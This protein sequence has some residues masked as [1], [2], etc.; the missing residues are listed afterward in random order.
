MKRV[1]IVHRWSGGPDDDWRPWLKRELEKL[2]YEV[3][4][5]T[6]PDTEVPVIEK[7]VSHLK[8]VIGMPDPDTCF[9]GHS[10]GCQAIMRYLDSYQFRPSEKVGGAIFVAGWFD[11]KNLEDVEVAQIAKPWIEIP[12]DIKKIRSVLKKSTL[13][14]SDNDPFDCHEYNKEKFEQLGSRIVTL[15]NAGHITKDSGFV[16]LHEALLE[17]KK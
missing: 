7:W 12:I 14:I 9:V 17:F 10:I 13:I 3:V 15:H 11:L 1:V 16:E 6:M 5:P 8:K 2:G 4:V